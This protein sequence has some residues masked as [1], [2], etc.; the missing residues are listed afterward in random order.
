[1]RNSAQISIV[2]PLFDEEENVQPLVQSVRTAM[3]DTEHWEL[4][5]VDDGSRD[6]TFE[7]ACREANAD[8]R[9]RVIRLARNYG[10]TIA[11]QAGFDSASGGIVIS[12][13]GDLQNDPADIPRLIA[14]IREGFDLVAGYRE[15]RMDRFVTRKIPSWLANRL[16]AAITR[17]PIRDNGCTL[18]AFRRDVLHDLHMYS[19]MHRFIP[20]L[21]AATASSQI[22]EIPVH[23]HP[24]RFGRSKY[25]LSRVWKVL[26]D[27]LT[28]TMIRWFRERP[29][30]MFSWGTAA[31]SLVGLGFLSATLVVQA[32]F[33]PD[34]AAAIVFPGSTFLWFGL[35]G[36]LFMVG[37]VAEVAVREAQRATGPPG[38]KP[39]E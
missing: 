35:A 3:H 30:M 6:A 10:Q 14:K 19:D 5:L 1:M 8:A 25:G 12:M 32:T 18:K 37:L 16:I 23:H 21:V 11:M 24:R 33:R 7:Y 4:I 31:A 29:L 20:A 38:G 13:D 22:A 34:K 15:S 17:V 27:L 28:M 36:Y 2:I 26:A 9:V 39:R